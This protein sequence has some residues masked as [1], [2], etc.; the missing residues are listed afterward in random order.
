M[1]GIP[2]HT[3]SSSD[4]HEDYHTPDDEVDRIDF[5]SMTQ[6]VETLIQAVRVLA[7]VATPEWVE[8]GRPEP[9]GGTS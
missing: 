7:D 6:V 9:R 5:Q 2:A 1:A 3:L 4:L 8:G